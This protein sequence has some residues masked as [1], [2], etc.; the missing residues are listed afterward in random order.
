MS[1]NNTWTSHVEI[2]DP[3]IHKFYILDQGKR[4]SYI[5]VIKLWQS[6]EAFRTFFMSLLKKV[7][8][9]AY[10]WETPSIT[11]TSTKQPFEFIVKDSLRLKSTIPD[12]QAFQQY[13]T[14]AASDGE[15]V[16]FAN[17][18]NNA[19]LIAP[20]PDIPLSAYKHL[21]AF[22]RK[23]PEHQKHSLWQRVGEVLEQR[24]NKQ[25]IWL[26]T[27]GLGVPWLHVR[28]DSSPKYYSFQPYRKKTNFQFILNL[29]N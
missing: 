16:D 15:V 22:I 12:P 9:P 24:L 17:L 25:P 4:L 1:I 6:N 8:Y 23:A 19:Y 20:C 29:R 26:S 18:G 28:L 27:S 10:F 5:D 2:I 11:I 13:F 21:A 3:N 7:P 14:S